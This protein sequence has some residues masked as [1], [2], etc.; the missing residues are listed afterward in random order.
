M[1][2]TGSFEETYANMLNL[3]ES[4]PDAGLEL[5][6]TVVCDRPELAS[7]SFIRFAKAMAYMSKGFLPFAGRPYV[8]IDVAGPEE[9]RS[10]LND[11]NLNHL[12][13]ALVEIR[14]IEDIDQAF[15][16]K[17]G[18]DEDRIGQ[19]KVDAIATVL[20]R[21]RPGR[22]QQILGKTKL[23]YF[24]VARLKILPH[25]EAPLLPS[26]TKPFLQVFFSHDS[27]VR[28]A[29]IF[30]QGTDSKQRKYIEC[31]L[32]ERSFQDLGPSDTFEDARWGGGVVLFDDGTFAHPLERTDEA[33]EEKGRKKGFFGRLLG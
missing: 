10:Y 8:E 11:D 5:I 12:E 29:L 23:S 15:V 21:C 3:C 22:V 25:I 20:E 33:D 19:N 7:K 30:G 1:S 2:S 28:S 6:S 26:D 24:G 9:L 4:D 31:M 16:S 32:Y 14:Q 18:R 27:I 13:L 17:I